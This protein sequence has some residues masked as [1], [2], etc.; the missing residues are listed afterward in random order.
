MT[1]VFPPDDDS[2]L[3]IVR[4]L[5]KPLA[6][7]EPTP[8]EAGGTPAEP[9]VPAKASLDALAVGGD[10]AEE[11]GADKR[12]GDEAAGDEAAGDEAGSDEAGGDEAGSDEAGSDTVVGN[13]VIPAAVIRRPAAPPPKF[14]KVISISH[15]EDLAGPLPLPIGGEDAPVDND[16]RS[17]ASVA[18]DP[19]LRERRRE[20]DRLITRKRLFVGLGIFTVLLVVVGTLAVFASPAFDVRTITVYGNVFTTDDQIAPV[21]AELR[22]KPILTVDINKARAQLEAL[23]FVRQADIATDFPHTV[24]IEIEERQPALSYVG[25]DGQW[26]IIDNDGRVLTLLGGQPA[27]FKP[28]DG[29]GPAIGAGEYAGAGYGA[30]ATIARSL[31]GELQPY[32]ASFDVKQSGDID[33]VLSTG[34]VISFGQPT[35]M[36]AKLAAV[37]TKFRTTPPSKVAA[38]D[39]TNP[40][41][42][43]VTLK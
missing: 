25:T 29:V 18:V 28:I 31:P 19:R 11:P 30:A 26:R 38:I 36:T 14:V 3:V 23:P 41:A 10:S 12:P 20:V 40:A 9:S 34:T 13:T 5:V 8:P 43:G 21:L 35:D 15:E 1:D 22:G 2:E 32:M 17:N 6:K 16:V 39:V 42:I 24:H 33:L 37:L 4:K 7:A 27:E